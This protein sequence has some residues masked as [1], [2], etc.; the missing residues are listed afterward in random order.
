M[1]FV[2]EM[3]VTFF[4]IAFQKGDFYL[5]FIRFIFFFVAILCLVGRIWVIVR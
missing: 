3:P 4:L 2:T 1:F 5:F